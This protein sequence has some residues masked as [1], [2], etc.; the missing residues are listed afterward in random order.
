M[1][2]VVYSIRKVRNPNEKLSDLGF[3][4]DEGTLFCKCTSQDGKRYT[5]AFDDERITGK[6]FDKLLTNQK[7]T[8]TFTFG[9][10]E[11][12][13]MYP[14]IIDKETF[15]AVQE[16]LAENRYTLGGKETARVPYLLTGNVICA[17]GQHKIISGQ[18]QCKKDCRADC[19]S[20]LFISDYSK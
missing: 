19:D 7:Y 12:N 17:N 2:K 15:D 16:R 20:L 4:N 9:G 5:Q 1:K 6:S 3:L 11:C 18:I 14:P 13:N 8:G 10:R